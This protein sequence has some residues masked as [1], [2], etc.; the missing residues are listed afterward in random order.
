MFHLPSLF[1]QASPFLLLVE[2]PLTAVILLGTVR[3]WIRELTLPPRHSL[4]RPRVSCVVTCY[5]EGMDV[6]RTLLSLCEQ[7]YPGEIELI[8]VVDGAAVNTITMEAVRNFHCDP[9]LYPRRRIRP[10]AK[11]QRGGRVSSLNAGLAMCSG[12]IVMA[13][14]GDT[15]FDNDMVN[16]IIR[17]FE[18]P[19]VPAV[20]GN[21]RVRNT[22]HS[23][24]TAMQAIEYLMS[25]G[26][27]RIGL[28]EWNVL[29]NISGAFGCF[30]RS[31]IQQIGGWDTHTSEDLDLTLR[32]KSYF[33]R[34]PN[35]RIPFEPRAMGHTDVPRTFKDFLMQRLRWDGDL[36]FI[37]ARKHPIN[38]NPNLIG[39]PNFLMIVF[40]G[41]F[42]QVVL[43]FIILIYSLMLL[44]TEPWPRLLALIGCIYAAYLLLLSLQFLLV[45]ILTSEQPKKDMRL[46]PLLPLFPLAMFT[47]RC[48]SA[49]AM[50]NELLRRSHEETSM[51]P[52]WV[53]SRAR[54]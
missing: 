35:M 11:W 16:V 42:V 50:L 51:A 34:H 28:A 40:G 12:E 46:V 2:L 20:A 33:R 1:I 22:W 3:W 25:I 39:W 32:I 18:D 41:M 43:P 5:S 44:V 53:M 24:T 21:L 14:D 17:H 37:Y 6:Q 7:T 31:F 52:W 15:S 4:Y 23:L 47:I 48:W 36:L 30:R 38:I 10:I 45:L 54:F 27:A 9:E 13:L 29:N 8:P 49:I 19:N 26:M